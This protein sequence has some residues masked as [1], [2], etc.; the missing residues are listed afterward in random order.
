VPALAFDHAGVTRAAHQRLVAR[1][2]RSTIAFQF[3]PEVFTLGELQEIDAILLDAAPDKR[4]FRKWA[5]ALEQI[6]ETGALRRRGRHRTARLDRL[7]RRDRVH[8]IR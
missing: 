6:E 8:H 5:L 7:T 2:D 3:P 4:N 1:L